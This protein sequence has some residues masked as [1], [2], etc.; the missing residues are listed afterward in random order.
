MKKYQVFI[1]GETVD[2]VVPNKF[3]T[4]KLNGIIGLIMKNLLEFLSITVFFQ[5]RLTAKKLF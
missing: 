1:K 5:I 2:L 3:A 4:E